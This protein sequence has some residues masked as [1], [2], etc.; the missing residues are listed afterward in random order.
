MK[1]IF[2]EGFMKE[3]AYLWFLSQK[4]TRRETKM[5][6]VK[7]GEEVCLLSGGVHIRREQRG[8]NERAER[9]AEE[10][11]EFCS[12]GLQERRRDR[13]DAAAFLSQELQM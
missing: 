9:T 8:G 4:K 11:R 2:D 5:K 12:I 3:A 7:G 6:R 10:P 13:R 1:T